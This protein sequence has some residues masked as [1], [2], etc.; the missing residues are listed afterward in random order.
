MRIDSAQRITNP[1][2]NRRHNGVS[3][4][5]GFAL[6]QPA[7]TGGGAATQS[8]APVAALDTLIA[9]QEVDGSGEERQRAVGRGRELLDLLDALKLDVI[10]G[11]ED[12]QT[13]TKLRD[14]AAQER[15]R[16]DERDL[17]GVLDEIELR[18]S[19]ELAKRGL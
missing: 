3:N 7:E 2:R 8:G 12:P 5:D 13:L 16:L 19:V 18:A 14:L 10:V 1:V 4:G 6:Q 15:A 11:I 17:Q 9:L